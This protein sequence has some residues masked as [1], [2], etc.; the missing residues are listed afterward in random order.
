MRSSTVSL[1]T[2]YMR[3]AQATDLYG[4]IRLQDACF[5]DLGATGE[6]LKCHIRDSL[7]FPRNSFCLV[8]TT[9]D[10]VGLCAATMSPP[11]TGTIDVLCVDEGYRR[12]K[13][14]T[15]LLT[16]VCQSLTE[17]G[18]RRILLNVELANAG[19]QKLY[20]NNGFEEV[21]QISG[22]YGQGR[23]SLEM[24]LNPHA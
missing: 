14:G 15:E 21:A 23:H 24:I 17:A 8:A 18:A 2:V 9:L 16:R 1:S 7:H 10:P 12:R 22:T 4:L 11:D 5:P 19:A 20:R 6:W 3:P 13:I